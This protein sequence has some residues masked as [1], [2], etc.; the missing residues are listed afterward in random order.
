VSGPL[1]GVR[2]LELATEIAGPYA[3]KLLADAGARVVKVAARN[4][5][6]PLERWTACGAV[7]A[8]GTMAPLFR[9]LNHAKESLPVDATTPDG[10][11]VVLDQ[12]AHADLVIQNTGSSLSIPWTTLQQ[13]APRTSLISIS[14]FGTTGPWANWPATEFTLQAW[15]GSTAA[16]GEVERPPLAAGGRIGEWLGGGYAALGAL[17][18]LA[19]HQRT[20]ERTH[21]DVSLLEAMHLSMAPFSTLADSLSGGAAPLPRTVEIP[22]IAP[23]ADGY[24][25]FCTI[26]HQQWRDF[27]V[28]IEHGDRVDDEGL[29]HYATRNERRQEV[30]ALI[31][32]WTRAHTTAEII[33]RATL[34]RIPVAPIGT[35]ATV[36]TFE[37]FRDRG[38]YVPLPGGADL[39][40]PRP[41][42]RTLRTPTATI[43][44]PPRPG[45]GHTAPEPTGTLPFAGLRVLDMTVF[46]AGPFVGHYLAALGA[47]VIKLESIQRPDGIRF[48]STQR[49]T[50]DHWWEWSALFQGINANKRGITLDLSRPEGLAL[51]HRV[52]AQ[53][54][55]VVENFSPRVLDN[56]GLH[57]DDLAQANPG[58]VMV[59][60][61]AFGLDGPWRDRTGFAQTMEQVSGM[62]WVTGFADG[63][64]TIPRGPCDPLAGLHACFALLVA[65]EERRRTGRGRLIEA[66]MVEAALNA[67]ADQVLEW[68]VFGQTAVR[69]GNHGPVG[70]PQNLYPCRGADQWVA[71]AVATDAQWAALR[72][73]LGDPAWAAAPSLAD[74]AGRRAA[75]PTLDAALATWCAEQDVFDL[76]H[77]LIAAGIPAAPVVPGRHATQH[78]QL[79]ARHFFESV[80]HPV[81][82]PH[83]VPGLPMRLSS[84]PGPWIT[85][86]APTLG[87]HTRTVLRERLGLDEAALDALTRAGI[88]GERPLGT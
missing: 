52:I 2:V 59:R 77:R 9:F 13:Q 30:Y 72:G 75:H 51:A 23:T 7:P 16:R 26:T 86:P 43:P 85:R 31:H 18:A 63:A 19:Q 5:P 29:A 41:P 20:G 71:I 46:W 28:L 61:P 80:F 87:Q 73:V 54:D 84:H 8:P 27:L 62:A 64:P 68:Q 6:D 82:G 38:V 33:E 1:A 69:T 25:G 40:Q 39:R 3:G 50:A 67:T 34:L 53:V 88:I 48:A 60:M 56:L 79:N 36:A 24:V 74:A 49:P 12:A 65:L 10:H 81:A 44:T 76:A 21:V 66:T 70:A 15:C 58:L 55:V 37:Q 47:D 78:T 45:A 42:F 17:T 83:A 35:G 14:P 57:Y 4:H 11:A 32:A 22:S